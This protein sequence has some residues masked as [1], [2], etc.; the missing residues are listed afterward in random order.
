MWKTGSRVRPAWSPD[1]RFL[2]VGSY[3]GTVRI[4]DMERAALVHTLLTPRNVLSV[5]RVAWSPN[6]QYVAAAGDSVAWVW[7]CPDWN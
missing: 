5:L 3:N 6:G 7:E 4:W 1:S 2:A